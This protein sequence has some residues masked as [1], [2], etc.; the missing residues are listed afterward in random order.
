MTQPKSEPVA[1]LPC[2]FCGKAAG[3]RAEY[4]PDCDEENQLIGYTVGCGECD[5]FQFDAAEEFAIEAWN[6]RL[7]APYQQVAED[8]AAHAQQA[9]DGAEVLRRE[10][11]H[12]RAALGR[13]A[14]D[15]TLEADLLCEM[16]TRDRYHD[17]A[18]SLASAI[19]T[20]TGID[21][22]E[23][24]SANDPWQSALD[25]AED[26]AHRCHPPAPPAGVPEGWKL[27]PAEPT[28]EQLVAARNWSYQKY[29]KAIG[30]ADAKG[31]YGAML[32]ASPAPPA[33]LRDDQIE[34]APDEPTPEGHYRCRHGHFHLIIPDFLDEAPPAAQS[35]ENGNVE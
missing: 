20:L 14:S 23:H 30:D 26:Y 21:I 8:M 3:M 34:H 9:V 28:V 35:D 32:A 24:S 7:K 12:L 15:D 6:R 31:C 13:T 22:G 10:N 33:P 11:G 16:K 17:I 18:D 1:L 19:A 25:A 27:V 5:V 29:G 4:Q 2:P